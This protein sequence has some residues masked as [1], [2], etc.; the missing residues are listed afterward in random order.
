MNFENKCVSKIISNDNFTPPISKEDDGLSLLIIIL[1]IS[2]CV[3][4][5]IIIGI[6]IYKVYRRKKLR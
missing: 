2:C 1:I 3:L 6:V 5:S 4:L